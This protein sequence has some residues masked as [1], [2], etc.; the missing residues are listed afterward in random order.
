[1][2]TLELLEQ[3]REGNRDFQGVNL[4]RRTL[5]RVDLRGANLCE[6]RLFAVNPEQADLTGANVSGADF[7]VAIK[8]V[9]ALEKADLRYAV[10]READLGGTV[11]AGA[12]LE[13][14]I[15]GG[16]NCR[17]PG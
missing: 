17:G 3:N 7:L 16:L 5:T 2:K 8:Q 12:D 10:M 13:G 14:L 6:A 15:L 1:V 4:E 11:L 9:R